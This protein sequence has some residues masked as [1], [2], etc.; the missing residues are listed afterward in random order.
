MAMAETKHALLHPS[1]GRWTFSRKARLV[2]AVAVGRLSLVEV[3]EA[4]ISVEEFVAWERA[5]AA[6]GRLGLR[7]RAEAGHG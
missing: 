7:R 2:Q 4:G 1:S 6:R 3:V 5:I